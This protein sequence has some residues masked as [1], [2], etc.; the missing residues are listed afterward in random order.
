MYNWFPEVCPELG[1]Q[2]RVCMNKGTCTGTIGFPIQNQTCE[3][4]GPTEPL[5]DIYLT[6]LDKEN[7]IC[8]GDNLKLKIRLENY[9]KV[10]LLD[11]FMTYW[12]IDKNNTLISELKDTRAVEAE[13]D[14]DVE[15]DISDSLSEGVYRVY[16][17]INYDENKNCFGWRVF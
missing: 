3:Y 12:V 15:L 4:A 10:E 17:Q 16:A 7:G 13:K 6:L 2:E 5:F 1:I 11:A 14:F 8:S 9:G